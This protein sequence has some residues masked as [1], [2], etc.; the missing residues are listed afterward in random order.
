MTEVAVSLTA[1]REIYAP[2][3]EGLKKVLKVTIHVRKNSLNTDGIHISNSNNIKIFHSTIGTEDDCTLIDGGTTNL[4][5]ED[6]HYDPGYDISIQNSLR[7][8]TWV[9]HYKFF[10][11]DVIFQYILMEN[12]KNDIQVDPMRYTR[13]SH[14]MHVKINN[15]KYIDIHESSAT[16]TALKFAYNDRNLCTKLKL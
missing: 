4:W 6:I 9:T 1:V 5:I 10:V 14:L 3:D 7:I 16:E 12:V 13:V 2:R 11:T 15:V 8:K